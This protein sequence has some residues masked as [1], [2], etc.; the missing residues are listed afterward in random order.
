[1]ELVPKL[2]FPT[3]NA[4]VAPSPRPKKLISSGPRYWGAPPTRTS[5][6]SVSALGSSPLT[7]TRAGENELTLVRVGAAQVYP[8]AKKVTVTDAFAKGVARN[9]VAIFVIF[10]SQMRSRL[11]PHGIQELRG[12]A[13]LQP[14]PRRWCPCRP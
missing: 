13:V 1:M 10:K 4:V 7:R 3:P 12:R 8:V 9:G 14:S 2:M 11:F 6:G 5:F